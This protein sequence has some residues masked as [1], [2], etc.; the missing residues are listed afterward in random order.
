[1]TKIDPS[2]G[3]AIEKIR[4]IL[5]SGNFEQFKSQREGDH[6]EAKQKKPY[7]ID[8]SDSTKRFS[9]LVKLVSD[10]ASFA[11][12]HGGYIVC[13]L[14]TQKLQDSPHDVVVGIDLLRHISL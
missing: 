7:E 5:E 10:I 8:S 4:K 1:M 13:G 6:F 3:L 9:A 11:N 12:G 14:Q 2:V